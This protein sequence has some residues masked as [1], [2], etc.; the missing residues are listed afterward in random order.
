MKDLEI[1]LLLALD[2]VTLG[3]APAWTRGH[4]RFIDA[5]LGLIHLCIIQISV[6]ILG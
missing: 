3:F 5:S 6:A 2:A 4:F 1:L